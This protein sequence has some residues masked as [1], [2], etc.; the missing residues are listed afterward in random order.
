MWAGGWCIITKK[1]SLMYI[2]AALNKEKQVDFTVLI[3]H[4]VNL[5]VLN[6]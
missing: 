3:V 2:N 6:I 4:D 1:I 5:Y